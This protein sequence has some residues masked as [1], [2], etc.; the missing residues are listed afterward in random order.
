MN[1]DIH[2]ASD[3]MSAQLECQLLSLGFAKDAFVG[4]TPGVVHPC[5]Y[6]NHP[7]TREAALGLWDRATTILRDAGPGEFHGYAEAEATPPGYRVELPWKDFDPSIPFPVGRFEYDECPLDV[8]K[9]FDVHIT[10]DVST[11]DK[12]LQRLMEEDI[13][14][15]YVE[16][17]KP[18]GRV[19]RVYTFQPLGD[20]VTHEVFDQLLRYCRQAGGF[21]G[22]I[23]LEVCTHFK[24]FPKTAVCCPIVRRLSPP[25]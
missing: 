4:G 8:H 7:P 25:S 20:G 1:F 5:H 14:F 3:V 10:A 9:S 15:N 18:S 6:S 22:K 21:E 13:N 17:E 23:K 2:L 19:V 11:I 12:R 16:I 24:R